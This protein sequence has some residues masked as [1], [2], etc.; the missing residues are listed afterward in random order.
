MLQMK[1]G[2]FIEI[3]T[4]CISSTPL[5][6]RNGILMVKS[7]PWGLNQ[8]QSDSWD[9][10]EQSK[11]KS[12][13]KQNEVYFGTST[14]TSTPYW[15]LYGEGYGGWRSVIHGCPIVQRRSRQIGVR[16]P[17]FRFQVE[18]RQSYTPLK[19]TSLLFYFFKFFK[20]SCK[21]ELKELCVLSP[22][23]MPCQK[24]TSAVFGGS[25]R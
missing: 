17:Y 19:R 21:K 11:H 2:S 23:G 7:K 3:E 4:R 1:I 14:F 18:S 15:R 25:L 20:T 16:L 10:C 24:R 6:T 8:K 13:Y 5:T 22:C 9:N 12:V